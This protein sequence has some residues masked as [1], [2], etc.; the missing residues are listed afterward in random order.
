MEASTYQQPLP[1]DLIPAAATGYYANGKEV[2]GQWHI[3]PEM[4]AAAKRSPTSSHAFHCCQLMSLLLS[5]GIGEPS[6]FASVASS[7]A[8]SAQASGELRKAEALPA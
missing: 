6:E 4:A 8:A 1:R 7:I 5:A 3:Y 2:A